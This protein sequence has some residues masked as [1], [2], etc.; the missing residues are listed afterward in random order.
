[1]STKEIKLKVCVIGNAQVGK[2][3]LVTERVCGE[4]TLNYMSTHIYD[5]CGTERYKSITKNYF[6]GA[7]V[8]VM[9]YDVTKEAYFHKLKE[10]RERFSETNNPRKVEDVLLLVLGN[11][12]GIIIFS[13]I[14]PFWWS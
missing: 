4:F 7:E 10:W 12:V 14:Y 3:S 8:C 2:T 1:M 9:V 5:T 13:S 6:R 11:K